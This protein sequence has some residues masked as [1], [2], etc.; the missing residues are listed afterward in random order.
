MKYKVGD[1]F[2]KE[3]NNRLVKLE[4]KGIVY[5]LDGGTI[6]GMKYP[7]DGAID[8]ALSNGELYLSDEFY[9]QKKIEEKRLQIEQLQKE[10]EE[11][12]K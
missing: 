9:K 4:V 5:I 3:S 8:R 2:Y 7:T 11:L 12:G 1:V 6:N 10:I